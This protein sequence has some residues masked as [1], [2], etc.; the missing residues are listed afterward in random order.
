MLTIEKLWREFLKPSPRNPDPHHRAATG[1]W[2]ASLGAIPG[3]LLAN[4]SEWPAFVTISF[5]V[6]VYWIKEAFDLR[7]GSTLSDSIEDAAFVGAGALSAYFDA[8]LGVMAVNLMALCVMS[9]QI[10]ESKK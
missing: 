5:V 8:I 7:K 3:L 6:G 2:H 1:V 9:F 10:S 4:H